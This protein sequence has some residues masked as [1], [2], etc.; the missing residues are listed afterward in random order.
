M[1]QSQPC[2][3]IYWSNHKNLGDEL[4]PYLVKKITGKDFQAIKRTEL[5]CPH[6]L[7]AVGSMLSRYTLK[8]N[9]VVWGTGTLTRSCFA[10]KRLKIF[11][12]TRFFKNLKIW[13]RQYYIE[14]PDIRAV[15]G[16]RTRQLIEELGFFC[17]RIYGDPAILLPL[18]YKP[19]RLDHTY[20]AGVI[21]HHAHKISNKVVS[22]LL[23]KDVRVI[24]IARQGDSEIEDFIDEVCS[25]ERI[26]SSSLHGLIVAQAY[27]IPTQWIQEMN[28]EIHP[29]QEHKFYDYFEG[30][31]QEIQAPYMLAT[32]DFLNLSKMITYS[33]LY[34]AR[35]FL[36]S[37]ILLEAFPL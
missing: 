25:C 16:P 10:P 19:R 6:T 29:D 27:G 18:F 20:R 14:Q 24:S 31:N 7:L 17:P 32:L 37:D 9:I 8:R 4:S 15:R 28:R 1:N 26:Y 23:E 3:L 35:T 34:E 11:P 36:S 21:F 33:N 2:K 30:A 5:H 22:A 13:Q 12:V